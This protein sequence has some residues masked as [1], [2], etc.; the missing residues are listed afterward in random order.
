M[1]NINA[2][3]SNMNYLFTALDVT[4]KLTTLFPF[5]GT[6]DWKNTASFLIT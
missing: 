1:D 6:V 3:I 5:S 2:G 4:A